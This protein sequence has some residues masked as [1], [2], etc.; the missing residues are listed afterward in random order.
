MLLIR[1]LWKIYYKPVRNKKIIL[2]DLCLAIKK[3]SV[4]G[5]LGINGSGKT[6]IFKILTKFIKLTSG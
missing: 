4:F 1:N 6:T 3:K 2:R 5:L